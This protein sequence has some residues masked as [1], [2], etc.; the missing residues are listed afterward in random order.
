M[1]AMI[2]FA[3]G[4]LVLGVISLWSTHFMYGSPFA[5]KPYCAQWIY[6][7]LTHMSIYRVILGLVVRGPDGRNIK[8]FYGIWITWTS[9]LLSTAGSILALLCT[10][11]HRWIE[12]SYDRIHMIP[13]WASLLCCVF[14]HSGKYFSGVS[15]AAK[16]DDIIGH[17]FLPDMAH[18]QQEQDIESGVNHRKVGLSPGG[19]ELSERHRARLGLSLIREQQESWCSSSESVTY[20]RDSS[21][22]SDIQEKHTYR[23]LRFVLGDEHRPNIV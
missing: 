19:S 16:N 22:Q 2:W 14:T 23:V 6:I 1:T 5:I 13:R 21:L 12:R 15:T 10:T 3:F 7:Q 11:S 17:G 4:S 8:I 20:N 9:I 18:E